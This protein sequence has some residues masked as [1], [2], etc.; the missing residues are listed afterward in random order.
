MKD[1]AACL[2]V[3]KAFD[4]N[5]VTSS[6]REAFH[7]SILRHL[8]RRFETIPNYQVSIPEVFYSTIPIVTF[9][10]TDS[11]RIIRYSIWTR[12]HKRSSLTC[13]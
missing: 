9:T 4:F 3:G 12:R 7:S 11:A 10:K 5:I 2:P 6:V 13:I 1:I 8:P